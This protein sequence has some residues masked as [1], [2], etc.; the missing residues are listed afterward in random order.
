MAR[1]KVIIGSS[2]YVHHLTEDVVLYFLY[3]Q[4]KS[5][6]SETFFKVKHNLSLNRDW[7]FWCSPDM[8]LLEITDKKE[9][10]GYEA[11][12]QRKRKG[13]GEWPPGYT[14]LD[15]A[16]WYL[17]L[18]DI[19][20]TKEGVSKRLFQGGV[21]DKVYLVHACLDPNQVNE[22]D[23]MI[24]SLTPVGYICVKPSGEILELLPAKQNPLQN[25]E[26]KRFFLQNL[27]SLEA[28][29]EGKKTF[30]QIEIKGVEYLTRSSSITPQDI[31]RIRRLHGLS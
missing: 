23:L 24:L 13:E 28:F 16:M 29:G 7:C 14:G 5:R 25:E 3:L 31:Q 22:T 9:I 12:G 1:R 21:L 2:E 18:P 19:M 20:K 4:A 8:D 6:G 17:K 27:H 10:I 30:R 26:A 15:E 11:K